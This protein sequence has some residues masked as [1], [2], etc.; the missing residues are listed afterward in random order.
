M[1]AAVRADAGTRVRV[2]GTGAALGT[3][4]TAAARGTAA[5]AATAFGAETLRTIPQRAAA[6][7]A[8]RGSA[9]VR[10]SASIRRITTASTRSAAAA[11]AAATIKTGSGFH[12]RSFFCRNCA[13]AEAPRGKF[14][15][16]ARRQLPFS[17][18]YSTIKQRARGATGRRAG[19]RI[20]WATLQVQ[21]LSC[22]P[23][24]E[25]TQRCASFLFRPRSVPTYEN[26]VSKM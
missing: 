17:K 22:A 3:A 16:K 25:E 21:I 5:T 12:G 8:A 18:K 10:A 24:E 26:F 1:P 14:K 20:R 9:A 2:R 19:L 15:R 6:P 11:T 4:V 13:S 23:D 7:A